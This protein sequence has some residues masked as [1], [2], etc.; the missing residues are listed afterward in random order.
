MKHP[1]SI[2]VIIP[3]YNRCQFL[4]EALDSVVRQQYQPLEILIVDDGSTDDVEKSVLEY[5]R[6]FAT[7]GRLIAARPRLGTPVSSVHGE[8]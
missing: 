7:C 5:S 6:A 4:Y 2:S 8:I 3:V 1:L